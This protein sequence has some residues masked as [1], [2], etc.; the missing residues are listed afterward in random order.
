LHVAPYGPINRDASTAYVGQVRVPWRAAGGASSS[1]TIFADDKA[2][3]V[4]KTLALEAL[5][6]TVVVVWEC[7][8][9]SPDALQDR[10]K[11]ILLQRRGHV[12]DD[13]SG[14]FSV[15]GH[16]GHYREKAPG[17]SK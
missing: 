2:R 9:K 1:W 3:D 7:E 17:R 13:R 15:F 4:R 8:T 12:A 6:R 11:S 14:A 5:G 10:L 16:I